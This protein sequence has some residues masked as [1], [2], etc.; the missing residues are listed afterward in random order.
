MKQ[1]LPVTNTETKLADNEYIISATDAK[2][3]I[4]R[5]N[6]VFTKVSGYS[7]EEL[8]GKN[9]NIVR[10]PD[11]PPAAFEDLWTTL[12]KGNAWMG[13][14]KNRCKN[15]DYYWVDAYVSPMYENGKVIGYESVRKKAA[16]DVIKRAEKAYQRINAG[17]PAF[18][19]R[20]DLPVL[21]QMVAGVSTIMLVMAVL[22]LLDG[23]DIIKVAGAL[24]LGI[25]GTYG[26][27]L[28]AGQK[29]KVAEREGTR[30]VDNPLM[31]YI[32][33]GSTYR[34]WKPVLAIKMLE[35]CT[36]GLIV[37]S[38]SYIERLIPA[39][40]QA[41][42][43]ME[44]TSQ[45]I[46]QQHGDIDQ[47]AT[48]MNEM[49]ATVQEIAKSAASAAEAAHEADVE[50]D[51]G[52]IVVTEAMGAMSALSDRIDSTSSAVASLA[53]DTDAIGSV[54]D[55]IR[56]IAEQTNLLALNAAIEAAR[57]GEQGRGFA[58]VADEVRTLASRTQESTQEIQSMIER[59]QDGASNAVTAM[60]K[61]KEQ[62]VKSEELVENAVES[63]AMI[64]ASVAMINTMNA[65]I[66]SAAEEQGAVAEDI[67]RNIVNISQVANQA[68]ESV[69]AMSTSSEELG[70]MSLKLSQLISRYNV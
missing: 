52:K 18:D 7:Q 48:A 1:N 30:I 69:H 60:G 11:M 67:N 43:L 36:K 68:S 28:L 16:P 22:A 12:K 33:L 61:G 42:L 35:S 20:F 57:A 63:L 45:G 53:A 34:I 51:K 31:Q 54:L 19:R 23:M 21:T 59:L 41:S 25:A 56:G 5:V 70:Q 64:A 58:V 38:S 6:D 4:T 65:Q 17:K 62:T 15:G 3:I 46:Q 10:H 66:A 40:E 2:G 14:V 37:S 8:I 26:L 44:Q 50:A 13:V 47:V 27:S 29:V 49:M 24:V 55:V 9:H 39:S 32:Y